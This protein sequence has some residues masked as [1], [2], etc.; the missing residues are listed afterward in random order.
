MPNLFMVDLQGTEVSE[1]EATILRLPNV[2]AL[3]LFSRNFTNPEQLKRLIETVR[4]IRPDIFIAIDHE[5]GIVQRFQ[6]HGFRSLPAARVYGDVFDLNPEAG[7]RLAEQYGEIMAKDLLDYGIDLSLAPVLDIHGISSV[8]GKLDRAFHSKPEVVVLLATAFIQGMNKAGM[9]ATGKH[10][11]GHGSVSS[12]SHISKPTLDM[13]METMRERD[14]RPFV[15]L[16]DRNLLAA[17]MPA[18]V[19]YTAIDADN[20]AGF[21]KIWLQDIL[22]DTL[23]FKGLVL[24]DCLGMAG[25]DIGDMPMRANQALEAGCDMLIVCNQSR[26]LL[27]E[28]LQTVT[29]VQSR[30]SAERLEAFKSQMIRFSPDKKDKITPY[31]SHMIHAAMPTNSVGIASEHEVTPFNKTTSI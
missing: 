11:P 9:P 26:A 23:N 27:Q 17:V 4:I 13:P 29:F 2:G 10:F 15:D 30:E 6:R 19:T 18:H 12:D 31:L 5:G 7:I 20:P 25:A 1:E 14:L 16:I 28:V 3:L 8:I 24:S 21:S 22:R